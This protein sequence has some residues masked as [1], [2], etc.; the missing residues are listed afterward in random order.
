MRS[1]IFQTKLKETRFGIYYA[2]MGAN[3]WRF[4][5]TKDIN[6]QI[7]AIYTSKDELLADLDRFAK[8]RG[9]DDPDWK[10]KQ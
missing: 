7:G 3:D 10:E 1:D 4:F 2:N 8:E 5:M 9:F 6:S